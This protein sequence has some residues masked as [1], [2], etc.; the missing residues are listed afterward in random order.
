MPVVFVHGV[1]TRDGHQYRRDVAIRRELLR[2][3][4]VGPLAGRFGWSTAME[5][6]FPYWGGLAAEFSGRHRHES[7]DSSERGEEPGPPAHPS[8]RLVGD[9]AESAIRSIKKLDFEE[10]LDRALTTVFSKEDAELPG[11]S[12]REPADSDAIGDAML[13]V[14]AHD[15]AEDPQVRAA[16][17]E[18]DRAG[19]MI[20]NI[21]KLLEDR[22]LAGLHRLSG[23]GG[24]CS[25]APTGTAG[26]WS[27]KARE[28]VK[29]LFECLREARGHIAESP[30]VTACRDNLHG[31]VV[32]MLGDIYAYISS[33][34]TPEQPGPIVRLVV[35]ALRSTPRRS[36]DE[37]LIVITHSMGGNI[38]Y[39]ILGRYETDLHIDAWI[40]VGG[41]VGLYEA[42]NSF[43]FDRRDLRVPFLHDSA[44][45]DVGIWLNVCDPADPL[46]FRA[47]GVFKC[48]RDIE[49]CSGEG[50]LSAHN[51]YFRRP[52]FY[53]LILAHLTR[54]LG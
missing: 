4:L 41:Q 23:P 49:F 1:S 6:V 51:A 5:I 8:L 47:E 14:A 32:R 34:G 3:Y 28:R 13:V 30:L 38:L 44:E 7:K 33:R 43:H 21:R 54:A 35:D 24:A 25:P 22:Y 52:A 16:M 9:L 48:V 46:T 2:R 40:S 26:H 45:P 27:D 36:P 37:P 53:R 42:L 10:V 11:R 20:E 18:P 50:I 39:D 31:P 29:G 17:E 19:A 15:L 12:L